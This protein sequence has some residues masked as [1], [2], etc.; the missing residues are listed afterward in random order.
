MGKGDD[1]TLRAVEP[2]ICL[3]FVHSCTCNF[4]MFKDLHFPVRFVAYTYN[5]HLSLPWYYRHNS[6][7]LLQSL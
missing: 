6:V 3:V 1:E 7:Q 4:V 5:L 2:N